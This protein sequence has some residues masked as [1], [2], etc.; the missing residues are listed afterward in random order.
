MRQRISRSHGRPEGEIIA[1]KQYDVFISYSH[2]ADGDFAPA[3]QKAIGDFGRPWYRRRALE[4]F[5]DNTGLA[6]NPDL[7]GSIVE[8]LDSS[9][10][11]VLLASPQAAQSQWVGE[12]ILHCLETKGADGLIVV[13]TEGSVRWDDQA[14]DFSADSDAVHPALRGVLDTPPH[15]VDLAWVRRGADLSKDNSRFRADVARIVA[16]VTGESLD[17]AVARDGRER[18]RTR[19]AVSTTVG[20]LGIVAAGAV[21]AAVVA[22][23]NLRAAATERDTAQEQA[24]VALALEIAALARAAEDPRDALALALE[25]HALDASDQSRGALLEVVSG[26]AV[27]AQLVGRPEVLPADVEASDVLATS[28]SSRIVVADEWTSKVVDRDTGEEWDLSV[29]MARLTPD[30]TRAISISGDVLAMRSGGEVETVATVPAPEGEVKFTSD[31][32]TAVYMYG[33]GFRTRA[34]VANVDTGEHTIAWLP[35]GFDEPCD[36]CLGFDVSPGGERVVVRATGLDFR[37]AS[38]GRAV[39]MRLVDGEFVADGDRDV[40][41][42]GMVRFS[43]DG[44]EVWLR[45]GDRIRV[46]DPVTLDDAGEPYPT[47]VAGPLR[48]LDDSAA[49]AAT[50]GCTGTA[51]IASPAMAQVATL[52]ETGLGEDEDC[53]AGANGVLW[54]DDGRWIL[55]GTGAWPA[56]GEELAAIGCTLWDAPLTAADLPGVPDGYEPV[57]CRADSGGEPS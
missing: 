56:R 9:R 24:R 46:V 43:D 19:L 14:G 17:D 37:D 1:S 33:S 35:D 3:L 27:A 18:R 21:V 52:A 13:V 55:T 7:W 20:V 48:F 26:P 45:D 41:G 51:F 49:V 47:A 57:G 12:E 16:R 50:T 38:V 39:S 23:V 31:S 30:G 8:A 36:G 4:V 10:T 11:F 34:V 15:I 2:A 53:A 29:P 6:V 25:A 28:E 54:L 22:G 5:R 42:A 44:A 32:E 40:T